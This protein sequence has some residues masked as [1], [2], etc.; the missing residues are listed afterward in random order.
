MLDKDGS[1]VSRVCFTSRARSE[2][3]QLGQF[4]KCSS[5]SKS[6]RRTNLKCQQGEVGYLS[7]KLDKLRMS[8]VTQR[9]YLN[10]ITQIT[11]VTGKLDISHDNLMSQVGRASQGM[12]GQSGRAVPLGNVYELELVW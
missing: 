3:I 7:D 8:P 2:S 6:E 4:H 12:L 11:S 10:R 1:H 9:S 5:F